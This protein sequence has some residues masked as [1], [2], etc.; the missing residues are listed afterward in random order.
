[1]R[2]NQQYRYILVQVT[3]YNFLMTTN[4][5]KFAMISATLQKCSL[6]MCGVKTE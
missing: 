4:I 6:L 5:L 3:G 1:M 2:L